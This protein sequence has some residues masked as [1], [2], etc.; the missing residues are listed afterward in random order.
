MANGKPTSCAARVWA[1][2]LISPCRLVG[3]LI[4]FWILVRPEP[5][6]NKKCQLPAG[7]GS[8]RV[9]RG[10]MFYVYFASSANG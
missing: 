6:G 8:N 7:A 4:N 2:A 3:L 10:L 5:F 1:N 9:N